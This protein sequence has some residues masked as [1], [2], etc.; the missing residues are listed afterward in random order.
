MIYIND[1]NAM[2]IGK[3]WGQ[4]NLTCILEQ[5]LESLTALIPCYI[6]AESFSKVED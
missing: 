1:I 5:G 2:E 3:K 6:G 4:K